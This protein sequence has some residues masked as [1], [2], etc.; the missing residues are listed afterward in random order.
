MKEVSNK[1][2]DYG[3]CFYCEHYKTCNMCLS[4]CKYNSKTNINELKWRMYY[5]PHESVL[6]PI[7]YGDIVLALKQERPENRDAKKIKDI[8]N[9]MI[10]S[11]LQD[12][13][14]LIE[15]NMDRIFQGTEE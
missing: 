15:L 1:G 2:I 10:E 5:S 6:D 14:Y 4:P 13:W 11:R 9:E 12:M 7:T 8:V 3:A